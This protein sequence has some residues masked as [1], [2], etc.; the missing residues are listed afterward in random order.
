MS[1]AKQR[2]LGMRLGAVCVLVLA[3]AFGFLGAYTNPSIQQ[4]FGGASGTAPKSQR[5]YGT[6][7]F[8]Y[9]INSTVTL[10]VKIS[11]E[12]LGDDISVG[13]SLWLLSNVTISGNPYFTVWNVYM[14]PANVVESPYGATIMGFNGPSITSGG[15]TAWFGSGLV[16]FDVAGPLAATVTLSVYPT[17]TTKWI[18][19]DIPFYAVVPEISV[20]PG[21]TETSFSSNQ[22]LSLT[23]FVLVFAT[24]NIAVIAY[25]H[26]AAVKREGK[27]ES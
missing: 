9:P 7:Q 12:V 8:Q 27:T 19:I 1:G 17:S 23:F 2:K 22:G 24:L 26:S 25:D 5:E 10:T 11:C 6:E 14:Q 18:A 20:A 3:I 16:I 15:E 4:W 21:G 13:K